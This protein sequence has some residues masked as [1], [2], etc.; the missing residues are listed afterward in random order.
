MNK[1]IKKSKGEYL[2]FFDSDDLSASSRLDEQYKK[3]KREEKK[4]N[5]DKILIYS[6]RK[7]I[8]INKENNKT[9]YW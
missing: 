2:A 4:N 8:T 6:N 5:I 9:C 3:F 7:F 1:I